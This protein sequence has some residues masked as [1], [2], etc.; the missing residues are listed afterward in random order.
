MVL[1]CFVGLLWVFVY[2]RFSLFIRGR[3][4]EFDRLI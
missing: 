2:P 1:I 4:H 3:L